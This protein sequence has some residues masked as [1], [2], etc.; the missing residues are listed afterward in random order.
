[1]SCLLSCSIGIP[2]KLNALSR[3]RQEQLLETLGKMK[4]DGKMIMIEGQETIDLVSDK[5]GWKVF[6]D[7]ASGI[8]SHTQSRFS[9][10]ERSRSSIRPK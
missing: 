8:R 1:M 6:L 3:P 4:K 5:G 2:D 10:V 9:S 7:W